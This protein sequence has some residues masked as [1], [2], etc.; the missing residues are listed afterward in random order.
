MVNS[1]SLLNM[2]WGLRDLFPQI[3]GRL[4]LFHR[5]QQWMLV[6]ARELVDLRHLA[7]C[8]LPA[9]H[10]A[11]AL[12]A[13]MHVQHYLSCAFTRH[14][15]KRFQQHHLVQRRSSRFRTA[16]FDDHALLMLGLVVVRFSWRHVDPALRPEYMPADAGK[17]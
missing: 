12:A 4:Q 7:F 17:W 14:V 11:N 1:R 5:A 16:G 8:N 6:G 15:E 10:S 13:G 3:W 2:G 9:E